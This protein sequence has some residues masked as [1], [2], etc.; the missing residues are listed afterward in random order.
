MGFVIFA[1][2]LWHDGE[3]VLIAPIV[4]FGLFLALLA[5]GPQF[6]FWLARRRFRR[7]PFYNLVSK[8]YPNLA[9]N[10]QRE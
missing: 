10:N 5:V 3:K 1:Y 4:V 2:L 7:S 8:N 6:D 9:G